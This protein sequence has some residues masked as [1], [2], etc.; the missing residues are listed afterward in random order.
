MDRALRKQADYERFTGRAAKIWT[1]EPVEGISF[2]EGRL[3]GVADHKVK[4][5]LRG[6]TPRTLELPLALIRKAHLVV[7]F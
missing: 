4:L 1:E 7:E 5:E 2:F 6:K 3:L